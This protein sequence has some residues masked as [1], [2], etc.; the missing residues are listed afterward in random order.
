MPR[1]RRTRGGGYEWNIALNLELAPN[2][3]RTRFIAGFE[4][5][6]SWAMLGWF[7]LMWNAP[8]TRTIWVHLSFRLRKNC[9]KREKTTMADKTACEMA[10]TLVFTITKK[11]ISFR[12]FYDD[13]F[14]I[15][16]SARS[17]R[18][19]A[20]RKDPTPSRTT[21]V[22][23]CEMFFFEHE[24]SPFLFSLSPINTPDKG[25]KRFAVRFSE[26]PAQ[27][28][29]AASKNEAENEFRRVSVIEAFASLEFFISNVSLTK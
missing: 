17:S 7:F 11:E 4:S 12:Y 22:D 19:L 28:V 29:A 23:N 14:H 15:T 16:I 18:W 2:H 9:C 21:T 27:H 6:N 13:A 8:K 25:L 10:K 5:S 20:A 24:F 26:K 3:R 1:P